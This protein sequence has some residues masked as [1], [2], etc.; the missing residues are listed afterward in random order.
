LWDQRTRASTTFLLGFLVFSALALCLGFHFREHYFILVLP[1][2]S[3]LVGV[4]ITNLAHL[5]AGR[6]MVMRFIPLL[7]FGAALSLPILLRKTFF[8]EA[9]P[10]EACQMIYG[11]NPFAESVRIADY[12]REHTSR[13]DTIAVLGSEPEIYF[14][15]RRHSA[16]GYLYTYGLMEPQKY[17]QQMQQEMIHE[18]ERASPKYVISVVMFYSWLWRPASE[19]LIF[20]WANEY[21][22]QNYDVAG[23]VNITP[24]DTDYFFGDVPPSVENLENYILIYKRKP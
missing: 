2:V 20:T 7:L 23:L 12:L 18:I 1:A 6:M 13:D 15:A 3:L 11:P 9:S 24:K 10:V 17:A 16:T 8:L 19:R 22:A 21:T 5:I 4:A 14:Y